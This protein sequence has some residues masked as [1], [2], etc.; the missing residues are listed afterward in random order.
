MAKDGDHRNAPSTVLQVLPRLVTGGV[1]RRTGRPFVTTFH[2][3]Y[4]HS[5]RLRRLYNGVMARGER[6]IAISEFVGAHA[7]ATYGVPP[8]RLRVIP[9]GVDLARFDPARVDPA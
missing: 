1:A 9:R 6:V 3:A 2:N 8:E 4:G 7:A 5:T